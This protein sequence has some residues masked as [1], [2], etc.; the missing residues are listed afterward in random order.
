MMNPVDYLWYKI[1]NMMT[2]IDHGGNHITDIAAMGLCLIANILTIIVLIS[3]E[4]PNKFMCAWILIVVAVIVFPYM[5]RK[6]QAKVLWKYKNESRKSQ[7]RGNITIA[8]YIILSFAVP[9]IIAKL[10]NGYI[11]Q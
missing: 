3:G 2:Y 8:V 10:R 5:S 7:I 6:K 9:L 1:R 4:F 11:C